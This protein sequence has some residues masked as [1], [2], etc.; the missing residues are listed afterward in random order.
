MLKHKSGTSNRVANDLSRRVLMLSE[1]RILVPRV[2]LLAE[3]YA[4]DPYFGPIL[5]RMETGD[6]FGF[7]RLDGLLFKG[8]RLCIPDCSLRLKL[9]SKLHCTGHVGHDRS[10]ELVQRSY[11]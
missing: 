5:S 8:T 4:V 1:L 11:F 9:V 2:E 3:L 6:V 10:L 7:I